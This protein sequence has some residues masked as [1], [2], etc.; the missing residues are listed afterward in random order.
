MIVQDSSK[1]SLELSR[2]EL[3][4]C[5]ESRESWETATKIAWDELDDTEWWKEKNKD[6]YKNLLAKATKL[7]KT[8]RR[9]S[10]LQDYHKEELD[11]INELLEKIPSK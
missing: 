6:Y 11:E 8:L 10:L 1:N 5:Y 4:E 2:K 3:N 9:S 7:F